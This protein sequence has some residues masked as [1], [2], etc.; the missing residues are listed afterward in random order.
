MLAARFHGI[1]DIRIDNVPEPPDQLGHRDVR[2]A[3]KWCGI[4]GTDLHEYL[5][6]PVIIPV[7][8]HPMTGAKLPQILGHEFAGD[9]TAVGEAVEHLQVGDRVSVMPLAYCGEC[10]FCRRG[11]NNLCPRMACVG[12]MTPW[13]GFAAEAVVKDYQAWP[14]PEQVS[15]EQGAVIEP[16]A[17]ATYGVDRGEV[18][19][20]DSVLVTGGGPIGALAALA[21][22]GAGAGRV[23]LSE[24]NAQRRK[25]AQNLGATAILDPEEVDIAAELRNETNGLGVDVAIECAGTEPALSACLAAVRPRGTVAQVGLHMAPA[26]IDAMR[27]AQ[28]ELKLVGTW[29][30]SVHDWPRIIAQ[31]ASGA[32][33]IERVVTAHIT[34]EAIADG[35]EALADSAGDQL[36]MLVDPAH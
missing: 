13:G 31:V 2:I 33:P 5:A 24:P 19:P 22:L 6:G 36:K 34:L 1:R 3:P 14:L 7:E 32:L 16:A 25:R 9:V 27:L 8:P 21:A 28:R 29:G 4:C 12:L 35:F 30:Y 23:Y 10:Y 15:Y 20:G 26:A 18:K 17:A 11:M